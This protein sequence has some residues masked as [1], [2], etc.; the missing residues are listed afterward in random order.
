MEAAVKSYEFLAKVRER[1]AY[2]DQTESERVT[3]AVLGVLADR[4][5]AQEAADVAAQL[6]DG[7]REAMLGTDTPGGLS[8][9]L[10][11][12]LERVATA[13]GTSST[14]TAKWDASAVLTTL[15]E[16]ISGGELN[17]MLSRLPSGY[18][19]LFGKPELAR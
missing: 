11:E 1:G 15:A 5:G 3:R 4:L 17:Q 13:L 14:E 16:A 7:V 12:F 10:E 2:A 6:P 18:A 8:V 9:G 19:L